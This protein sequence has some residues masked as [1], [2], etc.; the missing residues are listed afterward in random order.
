MG[1]DGALSGRFWIRVGRRE[2][3]R[4]WCGTVRVVGDDF[5][6]TFMDELAPKPRFKEELKRTYSAWG[7]EKQHTLARLHCGVVGVGSVGA[8]VA[9]SLA[10]MGVETISLIDFDRVREI[11]TSIGFSTPVWTTSG[12]SRWNWRRSTCLSMRLPT[13]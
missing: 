2:Y 1:T 8:I 13:V 10:R 5:G 6:V 3:E 11:S 7:E 12:G 9:E 4:R